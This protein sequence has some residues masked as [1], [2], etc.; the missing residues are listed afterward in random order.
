M[1]YGKGLTLFFHGKSGTG[2]TLFANALASHLSKK[3]LVVDFTSLNSS[4]HSNADAYRI[5]FRE[6]KIHGAIV[7]I[8]ECDE[9]FESR[10]R[11]GKGAVTVALR[12][13]ETFDGIMILATNRPQMLDEAM[14]RRI[15]LSLMFEPPDAR[16]RLAI[17]QK[18]IPKNLQLA[19][20]VDLQALA[21]EFELTGGFIKNAV[22]QAL[23][24]A[25][26]RAQQAHPD[27]KLTPDDVVITMSELRA[28]CRLQAR[29]DLKRAK[30]ERAVLPECGLDRLV[31]S[32]KALTTLRDVADLERVRRAISTRYGL[33]SR[34]DGRAAARVNCVLILGPAGSGKSFAAACLGYETGR[35]LQR[36]SASE[37]HML[38]RDS[39][40]SSGVGGAIASGSTSSSSHLADVFAQAAVAGAVLVVEHAEQVLMDTTEAC[41]ELLYHIQCFDGLVVMCCTTAS[42][43]SDHG[44][45]AFLPIPPRV[46]ALLS[47][48]VGLGAPNEKDRLKLWTQLIPPDTPVSDD[49]KDGLPELAREF[50]LT[51]AKIAACIRRA[52]GSVAMRQNRAVLRN[53]IRGGGEEDGDV[54]A[55][56][57]ETDT[58]DKD[59]EASTEDHKVKENEDGT[60][61]EEEEK[62]KHVV[63]ISDLRQACEAEMKLKTDLGGNPIWST[64]LYV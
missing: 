44:W 53:S 11:G 27:R 23:A 63:S 64:A 10:D 34:P 52:A 43:T 46:A 15:A 17:W 50:S 1:R 21:I 37:L 20:D 18:H 47:F 41:L 19:R 9:L 6:A 30:L 62:E 61:K 48:V 54:E 29:G 28:A 22:F 7:F 57:Q 14:H 42:E 2:K 38:A 35:P 33:N 40:A 26:N 39:A 8:D 59:K 60:K 55:N 36:L 32:T 16:L 51:G 45:P 49:V 5:V 24:H 12:E 31:A 56:G 3:L 58:A 13:M 25:V 4:K